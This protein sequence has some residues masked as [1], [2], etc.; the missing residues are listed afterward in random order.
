LFC[1]ILL[2]ADCSWLNWVVVINRQYFGA[3]WSLCSSFYFL[4]SR[5]KIHK[6]NYEVTSVDSW[7]L[8]ALQFGVLSVES[9]VMQTVFC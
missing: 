4:R 6:V 3:S 1:D 7:Q 5:R 9:T 2:L 8:N